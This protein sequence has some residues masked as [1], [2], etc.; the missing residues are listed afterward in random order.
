MLVPGNDLVSRV[1]EEGE[2]VHLSSHS[3]HRVSRDF[4]DFPEHGSIGASEKLM[5]FQEVSH[6]LLCSVPRDRLQHTE[7]A[8]RRRAAGRELVI[9]ENHPLA[10][11]G[12][13]VGL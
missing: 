8:R 10:V 1:V 12:S 2:V 6:V 5:L 13:T 4:A 3:L 7:E 11:V 9:I